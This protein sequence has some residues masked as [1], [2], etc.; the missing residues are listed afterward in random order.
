MLIVPKSPF[1][2]ASMSRGLALSS[3]FLPTLDLARGLCVSQH[4]N[5]AAV[6]SSNPRTGGGLVATWGP[7]GSGT[8]VAK[9][10][11]S[12]IVTQ[13]EV[14]GPL[15]AEEFDGTQFPAEQKVVLQGNDYTARRGV[16]LAHLVL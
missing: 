2:P 12:P 5:V 4:L 8:E 9:A 16:T 10:A 1:G 13:P 3:L 15:Q 14:L 11:V 7:F 6:P